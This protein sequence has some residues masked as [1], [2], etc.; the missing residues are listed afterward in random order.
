MTET[1]GHSP[2]PNINLSER[3]STVLRLMSGGVG[4]TGISRAL[5]IA[6]SSVQSHARRHVRV[7][8]D[9]GRTDVWRDELARQIYCNFLNG[10]ESFFDIELRKLARI[11]LMFNGGEIPEWLVVSD[12]PRR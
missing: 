9:T 6:A 2:A 4:L 10:G 7:K 8:I 5:G 1:S 11:L 3:R 12:V